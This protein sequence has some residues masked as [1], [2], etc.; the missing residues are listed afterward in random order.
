M[1]IPLF[2]PW[3]GFVAIWICVPSQNRKL[4]VRIVRR[5]FVFWEPCDELI[6]QFSPRD[7]GKRPQC[8][9]RRPRIVRPEFF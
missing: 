8:R 3:E 4:L 5:R 1:L 6:G 7:L 2:R 9:S